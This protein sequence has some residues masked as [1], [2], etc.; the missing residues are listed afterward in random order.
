MYFLCIPVRP[1]GEWG[2][3]FRFLDV[4][5]SLKRIGA[6]WDRIGASWV[7]IGATW[8]RSR[9]K[10]KGDMTSDMHIKLNILN[11]RKYEILF[12]LANF[13]PAWLYAGINM[14]TVVRNP[15]VN[16]WGLHFPILAGI[17]GAHLGPFIC[18]VLGW[19]RFHG[20]RLMEMSSGFVQVEGRARSCI[21]SRNKHRATCIATSI[22]PAR[23]ARRS[24]VLA[25]ERTHCELFTVL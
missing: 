14:W 2:K 16:V 7:R 11:L 3:S 1:C 18:R 21:K 25:D 8:V 17:K 4:V 22:N 9:K 23:L 19:T 13:G 15:D 5:T 10:N 20:N 24:S 6:S 12:L